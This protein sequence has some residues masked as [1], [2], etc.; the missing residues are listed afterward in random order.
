[1]K[2]ALNIALLMSLLSISGCTNTEP[3]GTAPVVHK[4]G[5]WLTPSM[6]S[7]YQS[8]YTQASS[9]ISVVFAEPEYIAKHSPKL[10]THQADEYALAL[11]LKFAELGGAMRDPDATDFNSRAHLANLSIPSTLTFNHVLPDVEKALD[12]EG[13]SL[14]VQCN[15]F[16]GYPR[17]LLKIKRFIDN[18]KLGAEFPK[19]SFIG[20][21]K[22]IDEFDG[23]EVMLSPIERPPVFN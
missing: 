7:F 21:V 11:F 1:M 5:G 6:A 13:K 20:Y 12:I 10:C 14:L 23:G 18:R 9:E 2:V 15:I 8:A 16:V 19:V 17:E 22:H 4:A 3:S